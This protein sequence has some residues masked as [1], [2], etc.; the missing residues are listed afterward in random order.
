MIWA[1]F[2]DFDE[3]IQINVVE[4]FPVRDAIWAP[5]GGQN[6]CES[7]PPRLHLAQENIGQESFPAIQGIQSRKRI[8][9]PDAQNLSSFPRKLGILAV[10]DVSIP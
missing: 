4:C 7:A 2:I 8:R 10:P 6:Y 9:L 5:A 3:F 1:H